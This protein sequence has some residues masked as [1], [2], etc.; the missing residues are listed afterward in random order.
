M[1]VGNVGIALVNE[2]ISGLVGEGA[3][4]GEEIPLVIIICVGDEMVT[5]SIEGLDELLPTSVGTALP[6]L[7][8]SILEPD[9]KQ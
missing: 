9:K 4:V 6:M 8:A 1:G 7:E 2:G 3:S 5:F